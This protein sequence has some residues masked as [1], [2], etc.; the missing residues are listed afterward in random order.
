MSF[1]VYIVFDNVCVK[2]GF[3]K[4]FGFSALVYNKLSQNYVLFDTGGDGNTL[5]YNLN[6]FGIKIRDISK[7]VISHNHG[8]HAGGLEGIY[9]KTP[10]IEIYIPDNLSSYKRHYSKYQITHNE[11]MEEI[12]QNIYTS[13]TFGR[14]IK[15]QALYLKR[16]AGDWIVLVGC[17]HPG[18]EQFLIKA[19]ESAE[20]YAV[21]GGFHGF[22]RF[23]YLEGIAF[24]GACHC[25]QHRDKIARKFPETFRKVCVGDKFSF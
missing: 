10:E 14:S 17:T 7:V 11:Q 19:R 4:G 5:T 22:R 18:L 15:E 12:D 8:D 1:K 20:I 2:E 25:T 23:S 6:K 16:P 21:I 3:R 13:G 9:E 24:I